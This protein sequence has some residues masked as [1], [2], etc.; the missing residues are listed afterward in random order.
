MLGSTPQVVAG[1]AV[2][3]AYCWLV[4]TSA[5]AS[6]AAVGLRVAVGAGV[7]ATLETE[8][9]P[10]RVVMEVGWQSH[11]VRH[12]PDKSDWT[13]EGHLPGLGADVTGWT[14]RGW[15]LTVVVSY[16]ALIAAGAVLPTV[17]AA[18]AVIR[19][20]R[21]QFERSA[22]HQHC[23]LCRYDLT[24][25]ISGVCPECGSPA[26]AESCRALEEAALR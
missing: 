13:V 7:T 22:G 17:A 21:R 16:G 19:N 23:T 8:T 15:S 2:R 14:G 20:R 5:V 18:G 9:V 3:F 26:A 1:R 12:L 10:D 24:G 4:T 11:S 6:I 25:N